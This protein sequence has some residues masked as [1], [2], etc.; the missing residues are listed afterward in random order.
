MSV[1][2]FGDI[3]FQS[4]IVQRVI[5]D[6]EAAIPKEIKAN[7][8]GPAVVEMGEAVMRSV[9]AEVVEALSSYRTGSKIVVPQST[10][11]VQAMAV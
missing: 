11:L 1:V 6:P 5:R 8:V 7:P 9:A 10:H 2:G 3:S 4:V